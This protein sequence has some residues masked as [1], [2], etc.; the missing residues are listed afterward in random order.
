MCSKVILP[1]QEAKLLLMSSPEGIS[2]SAPSH[3]PQPWQGWLTTPSQLPSPAGPPLLTQ[4]VVAIVCQMESVVAGAPVVAGDVD[5]VVHTAGVVLPL[6]LIHV[7]AQKESALEGVDG[8]RQTAMP[9]HLYDNA[10]SDRGPEHSLSVVSL[11]GRGC[12]ILEPSGPEGAAV[13][14]S[15]LCQQEVTCTLSSEASRAV[16]VTH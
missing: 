14:L 8:H 6:T 10:I 2:R 13:A 15:S 5:T 1:R 7:C 12:A 3:A 9:S 11:R 16:R 4:T